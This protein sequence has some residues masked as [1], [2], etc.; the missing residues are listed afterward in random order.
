MAALLTVA[1]TSPGSPGAPSL[2][3]TPFLP[4]GPSKPSLPAGPYSHTAIK[5]YMEIMLDTMTAT[6]CVVVGQ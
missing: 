5:D 3:G 1:P 4:G 6:A 2:P